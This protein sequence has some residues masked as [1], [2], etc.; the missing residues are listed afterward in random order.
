MARSRGSFASANV[1][2]R[3]NSQFAKPNQVYGH[4]H[5]GSGATTSTQLWAAPSEC[6]LCE[7]PIAKERQAEFKV[8]CSDACERAAAVANRLAEPEPAYD[9]S[10]GFT[11]SVAWATTGGFGSTL[12]V[13]TG[14]TLTSGSISFSSVNSTKP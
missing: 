12:S 7:S 9:P 3:F 13:Y 6:V 1:W 11:T 2:K 14:T 8:H 5:I 4:S 10:Y